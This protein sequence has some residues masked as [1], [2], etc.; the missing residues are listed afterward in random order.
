MMATKSA[1]KAEIQAAVA[2][3]GRCISAAAAG[4]YSSAAQ[5]ESDVNAAR[6]QLAAAMAQ[7]GPLW[8]NDGAMALSA[9][10]ALAASLL[11]LQAVVTDATACTVE[12]VTEQTSVIQLSMRYYGDA[13]RYPELLKLNPHIRRGGFIQAGTQLVRHVR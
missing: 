1:T 8:G 2:A 9:L 3:A 12:T 11:D 4:Q 13:T 7:V 5:V 10:R 6:S